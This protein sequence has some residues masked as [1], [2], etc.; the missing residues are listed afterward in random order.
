MLCLFEGCDF[1]IKKKMAT[2]VGVSSSGVARGASQASIVNP[3][4]DS[5]LV[6][7]EK[8]NGMNFSIWK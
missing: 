4:N 7:I 2:L 6:T 1:M 8:M 5:R 3:N